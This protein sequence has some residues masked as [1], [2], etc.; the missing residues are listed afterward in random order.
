MRQDFH[1]PLCVAVAVTTERSGEHDRHQS[2]VHAAT[3]RFRCECEYHITLLYC[4][5]GILLIPKQVSVPARQSRS[6]HCYVFALDHVL[7]VRTHSILS[8]ANPS[9]SYLLM[10]SHSEPLAR[11][12]SA[13]K[14]YA[15]SP[16]TQPGVTAHK[17]NCRRNVRTTVRTPAGNAPNPGRKRKVFR[18]LSSAPPLPMPMRQ[19][20]RLYGATLLAL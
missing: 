20:T 2:S 7:N 15:R 6:I 14:L 19:V 5:I 4:H 11:P 1:F 16:R 17:A 12:V 10:G 18:V 9:A 8:T 3:G 13:L